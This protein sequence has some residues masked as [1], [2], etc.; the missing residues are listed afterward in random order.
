MKEIQVV[1]GV[2]LKDDN[3]F[4]ARRRPEKSYGGFWELPGG[5]V[6]PGETNEA[7]L[8][9]ELSE[10]L[11]IDVRVGEFIASGEDHSSDL[12]I[13]LHGYQMH[14]ESEPRKSSDHD[15]MRWFSADEVKDLQVPPADVP[16]LEAVFS[17]AKH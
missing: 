5:K 6:E 4:L 9:R 1:C 10:E 11:G 13:S 17:P 15:L 14:M 7:A 16:I 3:V 2:A 8:A 12:I